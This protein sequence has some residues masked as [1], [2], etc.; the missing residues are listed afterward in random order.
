MSKAARLMAGLMQTP[1][2][3]AS[4]QGWYRERL[5]GLDAGSPEGRQARLAFFAGEGAFLLHFLHF[6]RFIPQQDA[7][8]QGVFADIARLLEPPP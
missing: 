3:L 6:L 7:E 2:H 5:A 8:W 4:T 1:G